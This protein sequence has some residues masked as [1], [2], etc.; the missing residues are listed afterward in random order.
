MAAKDLKGFKSFMKNLSDA[1]GD[2]KGLNGEIIATFKVYMIVEDVDYSDLQRYINEFPDKAQEAHEWALRLVGKDLEKAL[3]EAIA[4]PVWDWKGDTRDIV[5]TGAL[6]RSMKVIAEGSELRCYSGQDYAA[7]IHYGGYAHPYG[8]TSSAK[9][10]YPPRPWIEA[11]VLGG[12]PV[13][14]FDFAGNYK[15][16]FVRRLRKLLKG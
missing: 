1:I 13:D 3:K 8:N 11:V 2:I 4:A 12:G 16:R 14:K 5:D 15:P 10:Y 6:K 7:L 9:M